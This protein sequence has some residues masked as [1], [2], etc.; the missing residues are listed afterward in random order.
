MAIQRVF[1]EYCGAKFKALHLF[2]GHGMLA[3]F[4][5]YAFQDFSRRL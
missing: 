3:P 4:R 1:D 2:E 5:I